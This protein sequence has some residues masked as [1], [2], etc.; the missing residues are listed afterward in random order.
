MALCSMTLLSTHMLCTWRLKFASWMLA[1]LLTQP[2]LPQYICL[3]PRNCP[4]ARARVRLGNGCLD[5]KWSR[6]RCHPSAARGRLRLVI[7]RFGRKVCGG[8][9]KAH[10][11]WGPGPLIVFRILWDGAFLHMC[12]VGVIGAVMRRYDGGV[13]TKTKNFSL[14]HPNVSVY[15]SVAVPP[16]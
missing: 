14:R 6:G 3:C 7:I 1:Y 15:P 11:Q 12:I 5:S 9:S 2:S 16:Q 13:K 4:L 10:R 8:G